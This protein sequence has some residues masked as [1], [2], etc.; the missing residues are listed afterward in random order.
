MLIVMSLAE[1]DLSK[2][3]ASCEG[4]SRR[5]LWRRYH[6]VVGDLSHLSNSV[7]ASI[8]V[9]SDSVLD[10]LA[11][12]TEGGQLLGPIIGELPRLEEYILE[13]RPIADRHGYNH[14]S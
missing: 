14:Q 8:R 9:T 7:V 13:T 6:R 12:V 5:E 11:E 2:V 3:S 4:V 10:T 1:V